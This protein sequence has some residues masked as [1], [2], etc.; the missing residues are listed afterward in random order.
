MGKRGRSPLFPIFLLLPAP[1][2]IHFRRGR[3][4]SPDPLFRGRFGMSGGDRKSLPA[5]KLQLKTALHQ[6][7]ASEILRVDQ[8]HRAS[9]GIQNHNLV[10]PVLF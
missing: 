3:E 7:P 9:F 4:S 1:P 10:H 6:T 8:P 5:L 2:Q